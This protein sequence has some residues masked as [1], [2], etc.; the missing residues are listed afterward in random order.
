MENAGST[1]CLSCDQTQMEIIIVKHLR[2]ILK[3]MDW[4]WNMNQ[5]LYYADI[6]ILR[7]VAN[8]CCSSILY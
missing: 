3:K 6:I 2:K 5:N 4:N 8:F 1:L 7:L